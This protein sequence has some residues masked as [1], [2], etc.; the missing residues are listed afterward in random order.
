L[1]II[2]HREATVKIVAAEVAQSVAKF[3]ERFAQE[4]DCEAFLLRHRWPDG[5]ICPCGSQRAWLLDS[6]AN[7]YNCIDCGRHI[8][9]TA[10]TTMHRSKLPL[11]TWFSAAHVIATYRDK[12]SAR[13]FQELFDIAGQTAWLLK[14]KLLE[15]ITVASHGPLD[16]LVEVNHT[17][18]PLRTIK[19]FSV[20]EDGEI[21]IIVAREVA[22]HHIRLAVIPDDSSASL[23]GFVRASVKRRATLLTNGHQAYLG[24][25]DYNH[26]PKGFGKTLPR[27]ERSLLFAKRWLGSYRGI[28]RE[29]IDGCLAEY[30]LY[31]NNRTAP[32]RLSFDDLLG[33]ASASRQPPKSYWAIVGRDNPRKGKP[34]IRRRQTTTGMREAGGQQA[35]KFEP[36][37]G[38]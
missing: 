24:L 29:D 20:S 15:T 11:M 38:C 35:E 30:V 9:A 17:R 6:R 1:T 2:I 34:T 19:S 27:T 8:S 32:R 22:S 21:I 37:N 13:Q 4:S 28:R 12:V 14:Q 5:F 7:T 36:L 10:G 3:R 25:S 18:V 23:Q 16:G 31:N 33:L 26:D